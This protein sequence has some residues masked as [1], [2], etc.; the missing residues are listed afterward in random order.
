MPYRDPERFVPAVPPLAP[1][2]EERVRMLAPGVQP[3]FWTYFAVVL[4]VGLGAAIATG[5]HA[6]PTALILGTIA[7]LV[8]T[9]FFAVRHARSL[10]PQLANP[11]FQRW[12][13]WFAL[14]LLP[15]MLTVGWAWQRFLTQVGGFEAGDEFD[16][17]RRMGLSTPALYVLIAVF[18]AVTEEIAFR[19]LVQ[20]W[21]QVA[22]APRTA[23]FVAAGLFT[24]LHFS[25]PSAPYL[26]LAG[27]WLGWAK[28]KTGSLWPSIVCH[29]LHNAAVVA[30]YGG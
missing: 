21:L 28:W 3:L 19:G 27:C 9:C 25:L 22:L 7:L 13:A 14:S 17:L 4:A 16:E 26:F 18:P 15:V 10:R 29:G 20:H 24:V 5:G 8:V 6:S 1:T 30:L 11:G 23:L 12:E 2:G